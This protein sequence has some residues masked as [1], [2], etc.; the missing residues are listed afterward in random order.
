M[1]S[2]FMSNTTYV[3]RAAVLALASSVV[4]FLSVGKILADSW[5][6]Q[7]TRTFSSPPATIA[8]RL[9][10]L[11][12]WS[13][14]SEV[15][16]DLGNPTIREFTGVAGA[17]GQTA[18]WRGQLGIATVLVTRIEDGVDAGVVEYSIGYKRDVEGE[19]FG[20]KYTASIAWQVKGE[21]TEVTWT[22]DGEL[23]NLMQRWNNWFGA[24]QVNVGRVQRA[25]LAGL[26]ESIRRKADEASKAAGR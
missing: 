12:E 15:D 6:V 23:A 18:T 22:E 5:R 25:S 10:D 4:V 17:A 13:T 8:E 7:T 9:V 19:S 16:F 1:S 14:W 20:G 2:P 3:L 24:S 26:E 11:R 21:A